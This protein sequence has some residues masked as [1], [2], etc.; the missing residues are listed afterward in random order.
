MRRIIVQIN[1]ADFDLCRLLEVCDLA[2]LRIQYC[3]SIPSVEVVAFAG[4]LIE[5][6]EIALVFC[7]LR[8]NGSMGFQEAGIDIT[9]PAAAD[10]RYEVDPARLHK[11]RI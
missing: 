11:M 5:S 7:R 8:R 9:C 3:K 2:G 4:G 6:R 10:T 1:I